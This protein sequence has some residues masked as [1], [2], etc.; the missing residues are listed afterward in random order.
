MKKIIALIF[1]LSSLLT[2]SVTTAAAS[3]NVSNELNEVRKYYTSQKELT[4][5]EET[6]ALASTGMLTGKTVFIPERDGT[7]K[8]LALRILTQTAAEQIPEN[9]GQPKELKGL[10]KEDGSFGDTET[11]ALAMLALT[12]R[13]EVYNSQKAYAYLLSQQGENGSF[14]DSAKTTALAICALSFS[15]NEGEMQASAKAVKYLSAY[16]AENT[17]DLS[18]QIMG[19]TDG[20]VDAATAGERNLLETLLSYQSEADKTFYMTKN[21]TETNKEA[22]ALALAALDA[23]NRDSGMLKRLATNGNL[24]L[25]SPADAKPLIIFGSVMLAVGIGFWVYIFLHKKSTKTL[26]ETKTY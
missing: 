23:I 20:G 14:S 5:W 13:K 17:V 6:L 4:F 25:Y 7:T 3:V 2:L 9:D 12:A 1:A 15:Q 11:Q 22:T 18:W 24:S 19:I 10:Q 26:E 16:K 8:T 21:Q